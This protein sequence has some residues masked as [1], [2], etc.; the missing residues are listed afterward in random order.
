MNKNKRIK[1]LAIGIRFFD[2][3]NP[4]QKI[5]DAAK[6]A[7]DMAEVVFIAIN[8]TRD[9]GRAIVA[10]NNLHFDNLIA[11]R[12]TPWVRFVQ[13]MNVM[14]DAA[15]NKGMDYLLSCSTEVFINKKQIKILMKHM[16]E[17]T[18]CVGARM[19]G[20]EFH[21]GKTL[22]AT[23]ATIPWNTCLLYKLKDFS[24]VGF[25]LVG[26]APFDPARKAAGVEK[27]GAIAIMQKLYGGNIAKL[28][29]IP[30]IKWDTTFPGDPERQAWQKE[31][32]ASKNERAAE[33]LKRL[34]LP[35]PIVKHI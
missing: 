8:A 13:A 20:H 11:F 1:G 21:A 34:R 22:R 35:A 19:E 15:A 24:L 12:V 32:I 25:P 17:D 16:A 33:Q 18:L 9:N 26:D 14:T 31:K 3:I 5:V 29:D 23:G 7:S 6:R 28:V 27:I 2:V 10:L 30:G 4:L